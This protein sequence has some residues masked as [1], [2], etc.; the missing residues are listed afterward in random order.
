[1]A[2]PPESG[3]AYLH[4]PDFLDVPQPAAKRRP[5]RG[6]RH[7]AFGQVLGAEQR[8]HLVALLLH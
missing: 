1:M 4:A 3:E 7:R 6:R 8:E 5:R 2:A